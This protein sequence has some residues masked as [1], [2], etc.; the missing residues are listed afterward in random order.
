M[1]DEYIGNYRILKKIGAGGMAQ[2]YLGVHKDI[3][4]L[5]V[6]LKILSDPRL[7]ERFKQ[8]A[9]KLALLDG[10]G[11]ICQIKHFF[12]HGDDFVIAMEYIDG[13]TLDD[14]I[15]EK[16]SLPVDESLQIISDVLSTLQ[17]AHE[18]GIFHRDIK[19]SNI[20]IDSRGRVKIIDFGIAKAKTDPNLTIA[21]SS[22]GTPSYMPPEQFNPTEDIDYA[23]VDI[24]AVGTSLFYML[25]GKLPFTADNQFALRDAKLFNDPP[26]PRDL[27]SEIP[28]EVEGLILKALAKE[29]RDRYLSASEMKTAV[30]SMRGDAKVADLTEA[31]PPSLGATPTPSPTPKPRGKKSAFPKLLAIGLPVII[32]VIIAVYWVFMRQPGPTVL[33]P[34]TPLSP[35]IDETV[36]TPTPI[37][38]WQSSG[39]ENI[40]Y[41]VEYAADSMFTSASESPAVAASQYQV[42]GPLSDG[43]YYW[44]VLATDNRGNR[45]QPSAAIPFVISAGEQAAVNAKLSISVNPRGDVYIDGQSYGKGKSIVDATLNPGTHVIR[46]INS[47][48]KQKEY[49]DTVYLAAGEIRAAPYTFTFDNSSDRPLPRADSGSV[50]IGSKPVVGGTIFIDGHVQELKTINTFRL[51]VGVHTIKVVLTVDDRE[52][53]KTDTVLIVKNSTVKKQF[54]FEN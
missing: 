6:V 51:P 30:D 29:P 36:D 46:V 31:I 2:V 17:F 27:N 16:G 47:G 25:T 41:V 37:F 39:D 19:P 52:M 33:V 11:N 48:S 15:K 28:K 43:R 34:P 1:N 24:Y 7:V 42:P 53:D 5:K 38:A 32:V 18:K 12:N 26:K 45:S 13:V 8:E 9:D 3:P 40:S 50:T 23:L 22:C 14:V 4:N 35:T 21:G 20:M 10:H 54:D 44:R 49:R